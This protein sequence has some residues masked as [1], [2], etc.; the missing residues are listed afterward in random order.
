MFK[1][2]RNIVRKLVKECLNDDSIYKIVAEPR[3][4][5][6]TRDEFRAV[7]NKTNSNMKDPENI[8]EDKN[9]ADNMSLIKQK[10]YS[11]FNSLFGSGNGVVI[12]DKNDE[13]KQLII[14]KLKTI[15][16]FITDSEGDQT[17]YWIKNANDKH[18]VKNE[19]NNIV[20]SLL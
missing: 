5:I 18:L 12:V 15:V 1:D 6:M 11:I 16:D 19:F 17:F 2:I 4:H 3:A 8:E 13:I 7:I 10:A 14:D 20:N 9:I